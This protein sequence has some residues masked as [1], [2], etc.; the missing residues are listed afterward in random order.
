ME[1]DLLHL[2]RIQEI[3]IPEIR[4]NQDLHIEEQTVLVIHNV[5]AYVCNLVI[6]YAVNHVLLHVHS[7]VEMGVLRLVVIHVPDV[8]HYVFHHVKLSVKIFPDMH[9]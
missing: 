3:L 9:V 6:I 2:V 1:L 5:P 4:I 7:V 8:L